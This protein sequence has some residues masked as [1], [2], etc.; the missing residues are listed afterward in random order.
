MVEEHCRLCMHVNPCFPPPIR[1]PNLSFTWLYSNPTAP[2]SVLKPMALPPM[3]A[4]RSKA[5][6]VPGR[7]VCALSAHCDAPSAQERHGGA[8]HQGGPMRPMRPMQPH[9]THTAH[10]PMRLVECSPCGPM[11]YAGPMQL[12][13]KIQPHA[14]PCSQLQPTAAHTDHVC[15]EPPHVCSLDREVPQ[16]MLRHA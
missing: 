1:K 7:R 14:A 11:Q 8:R 9:A 5:V 12:V 10:A 15:L 4:G 2:K 16:L 3:C 6:Q 13:S